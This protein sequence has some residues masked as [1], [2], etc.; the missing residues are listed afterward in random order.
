[1][2]EAPHV[3]ETFE[4]E[5]LQTFARRRQAE[6]HEAPPNSRVVLVGGGK[7]SC[8][9]GVVFLKVHFHPALWELL[10]GVCSDVCCMEHKE[11]PLD[12]CTVSFLTGHMA[13][14]YATLI[15]C[16]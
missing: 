3:V 6:R 15:A 16:K 11:P 14:L 9:Q 2:N 8:L 1:M 7:I 5:R 12:R 13:L 4:A 10:Y